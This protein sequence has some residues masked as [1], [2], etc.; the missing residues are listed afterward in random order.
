MTTGAHFLKVISNSKF[1]VFENLAIVF[2]IPLV[3]DLILLINAVEDSESGVF[4]LKIVKRKCHES[5]FVMLA[6]IVLKKAS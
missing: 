5:D 3:V 2:G 6:L 4:S 1:G